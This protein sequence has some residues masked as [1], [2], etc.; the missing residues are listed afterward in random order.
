M[1][2]GLSC[3]IEFLLFVFT[4]IMAVKLS[5]VNSES[6]NTYAL[7]KFKQIIFQNEQHY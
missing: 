3:C 2:L 7:I 1:I 4:I 5:F 6:G